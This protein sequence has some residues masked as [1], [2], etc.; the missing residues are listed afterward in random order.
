MQKKQDRIEIQ[1][2]DF[3]ERIR[4]IHF[5][6]SQNITQLNI[7]YM[8]LKK[9]LDEV[10]YELTANCT[11]TFANLFSRIDYISKAIYL[12]PSD[13]FAIQ[14][15]RRNCLR[16]I[17]GNLTLDRKTYQYDLRALLRFVAI[18]FQSDIPDDLLAEI[19]P[20]NQQY[21][22]LQTK[23]IP[24]LRA[25]VH[26]WTE[27]LIYATIDADASPSIIINLGK[28]GYNG[29]LRYITEL[30]A[31]NMPINL[32][33]TI[34]NQDSEYCPQLIILHPDYLIDIS[35][36]ASCF[37]EYG[38]HPYNH[39]LNKIQPRK[40]TAPILLGNLASQF[41][42]DII[43]ESK[44]GEAHYATSLRKNFEKALLEFSTCQL[45]NDFH[46]KAHEQ[47]NNLRYI[48]N[49]VFTHEIDG[50]CKDLIL[51]EASFICEYLGLQGRVDMLQKD[52]SILVEQKSGKKDEWRNTHKE[53]HYIQMMLYQGVLIH[54]FKLNAQRIKTFLLYS[55]YHDGVM[56]EHFSEQ[57]FR[58]SIETRNRIVALEI[59]IANGKLMEILNNL[60]P[61]QLN[62][63]GVFNKLWIHYQEPEIRQLLDTF[64]QASPIEKAYFTRFTTFLAKEQLIGKTGGG[65]DPSKGFAALWNLPL[66]EKI[67]SGIILTNLHIK[68]KYQSHP[69]RA[70]DMIELEMATNNMDFVPNFRK[71]DLIIL[72]PYQ[73]YPDL[74]HEILMKGSLVELNGNNILIQLRNGQQNKDLIGNENNTFAIEH[75]ISDSG[76]TNGI[77]N[78]F[79]LLKAESRR[80]RLL[81][82]EE[83]PTID[84][85]RHTNKSYGDF[86]E[87]INKAY[88]ANDYF[89]LVGPPGTGKTSCALRYMVEE[90]LQETNDS[91]LLL[92]Y[93]NRAVDEICAMLV[94]SGI[95]ESTP[96][97][98]IGNELACDQRFAPFLLSK[99]IT[100]QLKLSELTRE[101][102]STRIFVSTIAALNA[103][104][105]LFEL[106]YFR[107]A[108]I[109]EASQILEPDLMGI[110]SAKHGQQ[111]AIGKFILIGDYKQLPAISQQSVSEATITDPMLTE[112]GFSDCRISL[113][114]RLFRQA[115]NAVKAILRKQGRM[116]PI[117]ATF[118][119]QNF[120][121]NEQLEPIPLS[122]QMDEYP[123]EKRTDNNPLIHLLCTQRLL[124]IPSESPIENET[125]GKTNQP[126]AIITATLL[127]HI[128]ELTKHNF[129]P[130][131][132]IG[133]IVP[134]RNQ[135]ALIRREI[136]RMKIPELEMISIDT[137]ERYQGSQRDV[138]IYSFTIRNYSQL[139]FLTANTFRDGD[140]IID[141]KLN[142][143]L[144]RARKQLILTGNPKI[145]GSNLIF[146]KLIEHIRLQGGYLQTNSTDLIKGKFKLRL[147]ATNIHSNCNFPN[148]VY[149]W[150]NSL[151]NIDELQTLLSGNILGQ[152]YLDYGRTTLYRQVYPESLNEKRLE[153]L[154]EYY[155]WPR[156]YTF[157]L[158]LFERNRSMLLQQVSQCKNIIFADMGYEGGASF[159]AFRQIFEKQKAVSIQYLPLQPHH[160]LRHTATELIHKVYPDVGITDSMA[161]ITD[162][163]FWQ[164]QSV[165]PQVVIF[166]FSNYFDR[167]SIDTAIL[168]AN[169]I[170]TLTS[171]YRTH[172]YLS[173]FRDDA[174]YSPSIHSYEV[175]YRRLSVLWAKTNPNMPL[176]ESYQYSNK[177]N[178]APE[179]YIYE[180]RIKS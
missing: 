85:T 73:D 56:M 154:Y 12:L 7:R 38:N 168:M 126:E 66:T 174:G 90:A 84:S 164:Q 50:F 32:L 98:R 9:V 117:L 11:T 16:A 173:I 63:K 153:Q 106:K 123:Y 144:T 54:N 93:T 104:L 10:C 155:Y 27:H 25:S 166:N 124:F 145:L 70:Y 69:N 44:C 162:N 131:K 48:V 88:K 122:H 102:T 26:K 179:K 60:T 8:Q 94:D 108:I 45:P 143:A 116:H 134:Y 103:Q 165:I 113:F 167:C 119:N 29:D 39:L 74:R 130:Q 171:Q 76:M 160:Q 18:G 2:F 19:P 1:A 121:R 75:D 170:N 37:R 105:H 86:N 175:F 46:A 4:S 21:P 82:G 83:Q 20:S 49:Q 163:E 41:L 55:K 99:R 67:E 33:D 148:Y 136:A 77:K 132:T 17:N 111:N 57:L 142:V 114:E 172:R 139:N 120:Y 92:S 129:S 161:S 157:A 138:I 169:A 36:L 125:S 118:V 52:L 3:F 115:P 159:I 13:K 150:L 15:M 64:R 140:N 156:H 79:L 14:T 89:L 141:R 151:F 152:E 71:G 30:L 22:I 177:H 65:L 5:D 59:D 34:I 51:L 137:V 40:L 35:V 43:N 101:L 23:H 135:I 6:G 61:E 110:L 109:D 178:H 147:K 78:L 24:Y 112:R 68:Q 100:P 107:L 81:L 58:K 128:Y 97:I 72:Y 180:I 53:D 176:S 80:R 95:A 127:K 28:S 62:T 31:E 42:D 149:N 146:Y 133:V 47:M 91:I 96:F 87:A 158:H